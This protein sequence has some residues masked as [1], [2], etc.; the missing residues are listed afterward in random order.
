MKI[1]IF[2]DLHCDFR[3]TKPI[4]MGSGVDVVA[5][6]GDVCEGAENAFVALRRIVPERIP[7]IFTLG[8]HEFYHHFIDEELQAARLLGPRY[9]ILVLEN[10]VATVGIGGDGVATIGAP[11]VRFVGATMWTDYRIFGDHNA[12]AAMNAARN[13]MNDHRLIGWRKN[14]WSRFRPQEAVLL[15][16]GSRAFFTETLAQPF[17]G[18]TVAMTHMAH[19]A[20]VE[21]RYRSDI[22][23]G[24][25]AN[26][27]SA[28]IEAGNSH[29]TGGLKLWIHGHT[30]ASADY[31]VGQTRM[32]ANPHGY[33]SE[34]DS[35]DPALVVE[36]E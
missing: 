34:N 11:G 5:C 2:S 23:T 13:G 8:N 1:Q 27:Y 21:D 35:F 22:L 36:V 26:D 18:S 7:V 4:V 29:E 12:P 20:S 10:D 25:F 24:A 31:Y 17:A 33:G 3:R 15:H 19:V 9:N 6:A 16:T 30:H 32:I 28:L 14:P